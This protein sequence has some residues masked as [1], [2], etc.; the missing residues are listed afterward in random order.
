MK[1][2]WFIWA[3]PC[4]WCSRVT[5]PRCSCKFSLAKTWSRFV[6]VFIQEASAVGSKNSSEP[7]CEEEKTLRKHMGKFKK[8]WSWSLWHYLTIFPPFREELQSHGW[9]FYSPMWNDPNC[10][11]RALI[12][13]LSNEGRCQIHDK[14]QYKAA[15]PNTV[16]RPT[17]HCPTQWPLT[18]SGFEHRGS[19]GKS[20]E[21]VNFL[22]SLINLNSH[23]WLQLP[24][25]TAWV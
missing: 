5:V 8:H 21:E 3:A 23:L 12:N 25:W 24:Y 19:C 2:L 18:T 11:I 6:Y 14:V 13:L 22:F 7:K 4:S 17:L 16:H 20:T 9:L 10:F 1:A 15:L